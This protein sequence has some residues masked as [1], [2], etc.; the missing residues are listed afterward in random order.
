MSSRVLQHR[1]TKNI[2]IIFSKKVEIEFWL[3]LK[4]WNHPSFVN[5]SPTVV[6]DTEKVFTSNTAWEY[7]K[8]L[9]L[10]E[11]AYLTA[12]AVMFVASIPEGVEQGA[13][14]SSAAAA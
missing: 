8:K 9:F 13:W 4:C 5:I 7:P 1:K 2:Y 6:I 10:K 14:G 3:V 11:H 12:S